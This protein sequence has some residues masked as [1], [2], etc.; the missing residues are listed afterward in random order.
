MLSY[1]AAMGA[2]RAAVETL[3][4]GAGSERRAWSPAGNRWRIVKIHY[5]RRVPPGYGRHPAKVA[6]VGLVATV[7][8]VLIAPGAVSVAHALL[9]SL[10][11]VATDHTAPVGVRVGVGVV[12]AAV[13]TLGALLALYGAGMLVTGVG[14]LVRRRRVVEGRVLRIRERGDEKKHF[15]H[16]AVDDGTSDRV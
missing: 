15:W 6:F 3:P 16:L 11:D 12:L 4:L 8:G 13:V 9:R 2:A 5:P 14:D 10:D 7:A 1:G